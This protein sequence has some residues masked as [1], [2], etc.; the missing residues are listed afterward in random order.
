MYTS[1]LWF[2]VLGFVLCLVLGIVDDTQNT[3]R[4]LRDATFRNVLE[5]LMAINL[6]V[7]LYSALLRFNA[8]TPLFE[9]IIE[10]GSSV[11][12]TLVPYVFLNYLNSIFYYDTYRARLGMLLKIL[13]GISLVAV[14]AFG[15][16]VICGERVIVLNPKYGDLLLVIPAAVYLTFGIAEGVTLHNSVRPRHVKALRTVLMLC[17]FA[18]VIFLQSRK[19]PTYGF[20]LVL[21]PLFCVFTLQGRGMMID[22]DTGL[23]S[24]NAFRIS[25]MTRLDS[26]E[27]FQL[28]LV[29]TPGL[30]SILSESGID[31]MRRIQRGLTDILTS[32]TQYP[33]FRINEGTF[34]ILQDAK[35]EAV[36]QEILI[37]LRT[38]FS[39]GIH[40]NGKRIRTG[41][42]ACRVK[43]PSQVKTIED[44]EVLIELLEDESHELLCREVP[45]AGLNLDAEKQQRVQIRELTKA[46]LEKRLEVWYQPIVSTKTGLAESAEALIRMRKQ[47]GTYAGP[48]EFIPA[49]EQSGMI[50]RVGQFVLQEVCR[51]LASEERERLGIR[52]VEM[53]LSVKECIQENL[54][55][56]IKSVMDQYGVD[57]ATLNIEVTETES[58]AAS[59]I[60]IRNVTR[61]HD[62]LCVRFSLDDFGTGYSN[63]ARMLKMPVDIV[64][65]DRSILLKAF[66][67]EQGRT[68]FAR[69]AELAHQL[70]N[71]IV[72]EGVETGEQ[73]DFIRSIGIEY[74]QGYFYSKPLPEAE[75]VS[76]VERFNRNVKKKK[77]R[78]AETAV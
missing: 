37:G 67:T 51:F 42:H 30:Q 56:Y 44:L 77:T 68:V 62:E 46:L 50:V 69:A 52:Y 34:A 13:L 38:R 36:S 4:F 74:I 29:H 70:G 60:M 55:E 17:I 6:L 71:E 31:D 47:D 27:S 32:V 72:S 40:V 20:L 76:F 63:I 3:K 26:N 73:A 59:E 19:L 2:S 16:I 23:R 14:V 24:R 65:F 64:K 5:C 41:M 1:S 10:W 54:P 66:E 8:V 25:V 45:F 28:I 18:L 53:N 75:Y 35:D 11:L 33:I 21:C 39:S 7:I 43:L 9:R 22:S 61:I 49:A 78:S 57:P 15:P 12:I 48:A 58:D